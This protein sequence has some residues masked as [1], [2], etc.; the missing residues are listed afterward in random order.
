M[1]RI[2]RNL[3]SRLQIACDNAVYGCVAIVKLDMLATHLLE[4]EH[5]PKKP[6]HC[7]EG[8][9]LVIPKDE[10]K[11]GI[12][13]VASLSRTKILGVDGLVGWFELIGTKVDFG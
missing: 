13:F 3:L 8:C 7:T 6:V 11:V 10:L 4:C 5:N 1:P 2:L 9:G 12:G